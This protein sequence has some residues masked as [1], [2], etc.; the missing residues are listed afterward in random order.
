MFP[1]A[2]DDGQR[3]TNVEYSAPQLKRLGSV[4]DLTLGAAKGSIADK[5]SR[6]K[7]VGDID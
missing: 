5:Q 3:E 2:V 6:L 1:G 4:A 7:K